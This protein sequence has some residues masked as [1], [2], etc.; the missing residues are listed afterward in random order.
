MKGVSLKGSVVNKQGWSLC[1]KLSGQTAQQF[2]NNVFQGISRSAIH[3][4]VKRFRESEEISA[5]KG[6]G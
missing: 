1:E 4:I 2:E 3:N 5:H 6:Q